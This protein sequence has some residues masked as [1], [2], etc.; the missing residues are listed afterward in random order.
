MGGILYDNYS[1]NSSW[2]YNL[3]P[4][5][6]EKRL[7]Y[8]RALLSHQMEQLFKLDKELRQGKEEMF[9]VRTDVQEM[10]N[11]LKQLELKSQ[12]HPSKMVHVEVRALE[13]DIHSLR[14]LCDDMSKKVTN[15]TGGKVPLGETSINF[16]NYLS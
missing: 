13:H 2:D 11:T 8:T 5:D 9:T 15:L 3:H 16:E 12:A 14:S 10:E 4:K 1:N 7:A 6:E